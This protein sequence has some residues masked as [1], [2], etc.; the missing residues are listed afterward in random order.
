M[1]TF[2]IQTQAPAGGGSSEVLP[3][4]EY[5]LTIDDAKIEEDQ[6]AELERDGSRPQKLVI[7]WL[8]DEADVT[9]RQKKRGAKAGKKIW[10]RYGLFFYTKANGEDTALKALLTTLDG[11][12]NS[13]GV[14][15]SAEAFET[16]PDAFDPYD[17]VGIKARCLVETYK[18]SKGAN[19][20]QSANK[21]TKVLP[22]EEDDEAPA[23]P[24][25]PARPA[26]RNAPQRATVANTRPAAAGDELFED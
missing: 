4:G 23:A 12:A 3:D 13:E 25:A 6:F 2:K 11:Y 9:P 16:E 17:L 26:P 5:V 24:P 19:I 20:G 15:F 14:A 10:S 22:V 8:L 7:T 1:A 21:V 18:K